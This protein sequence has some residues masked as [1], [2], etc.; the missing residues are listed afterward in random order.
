MTARNDYTTNEVMFDAFVQPHGNCKPSGFAE[1]DSLTGYLTSTYTVEWVDRQG[2]R[3]RKTCQVINLGRPDRGAP[4]D[5][6]TA[7]MPEPMP[8]EDERKKR[9]VRAA[10]GELTKRC[11]ALLS[12]TGPATTY[13]IAMATS[14]SVAT[15]RGTMYNR[16]D[17][18][19]CVAGGGRGHESTWGITGI[20]D[21]QQEAP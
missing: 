2:T 16:P 13:E 4:V 11:F 12:R 17:L 19:V 3:W 1:Y 5:P 10:K 7:T 14:R 21:Q 9:G 15:I 18:F 20:H 6:A 8:P